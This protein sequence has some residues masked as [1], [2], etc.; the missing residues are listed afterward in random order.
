MQPIW[1]KFGIRGQVKGLRRSGNFGHH[2]PI[3]AK[4]GAGTSPVELFLFGKPRD[5]SGT[6]QRPI[7]TKFGHETYFGV[8]R[9][10]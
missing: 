7:F 6:S 9:K 8:I 5:L 1:T 10:M 4:M 3:L 2:R